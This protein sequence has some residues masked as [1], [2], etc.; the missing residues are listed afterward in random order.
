MKTLV[1][2]LL[3]LPQ[4]SSFILHIFFSKSTTTPLDEYSTWAD[5]AERTWTETK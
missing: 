2:R 3:F 1:S 4:L 5:Q